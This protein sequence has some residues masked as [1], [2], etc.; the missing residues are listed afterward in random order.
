MRLWD[1]NAS[2][3]LTRTKKKR[4]KSGTEYS[5]STGFFESVSEYKDEVGQLA[6]DFFDS[7][8][9]Y[10]NDVGQLALDFFDSVSEYKDEVGQLALDFFDS[11]SEYKKENGQLA[12]GFFDSVS[13]HKDEVGQL[14]LGFFFLPLDNGAA[15]PWRP[16]ATQRRLSSPRIWPG[17]SLAA[18]RTSTART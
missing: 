18:S 14:A 16:A 2:P 12:L 8:S 4:E 3:H 15:L 17:C 10:K 5:G 9:E 1:L 6:L 13:E 7:V 11:V